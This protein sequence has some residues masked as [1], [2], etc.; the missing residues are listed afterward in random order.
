MSA[1]A[2]L[3]S[4]AIVLSNCGSEK[5]CWRCGKFFESLRFANHRS[6]VFGDTAS[7][8]LLFV[9]ERLLDSGAVPEDHSIEGSDSMD[10]SR[11]QSLVLRWRNGTGGSLSL[12]R[13]L[14]PS[15]PMRL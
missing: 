5:M 14:V 15:R 13:L 6:L 3:L 9:G 8:M 2:R 11:G 7:R 1:G 12:L 4:D 10:D